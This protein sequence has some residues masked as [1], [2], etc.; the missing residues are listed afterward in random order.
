MGS[1]LSKSLHG[2]KWCSPKKCH[3]P[4]TVQSV[5]KRHN[6]SS[7]LFI[8]FLVVCLLPTTSKFTQ[9]WQASTLT[10][11]FRNNGMDLIHH[12]LECWQT[13][14]F[15]L[16]VL[17]ALPR[18]AHFQCGLIFNFEY[19]AANRSVLNRLR[20]HHRFRIEIHQIC[21]WKSGPFQTT[22]SHHTPLLSLTQRQ[23]FNLCVLILTYAHYWNMPLKCG[24][25]DFW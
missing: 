16:Q 19:S 15:P 18:R 23:Q 20:C 8:D 7:R 14:Y 6:W 12:W 2:H 25:R 1:S 4:F 3:W 22:G 17:S 5:H 21:Q 11:A 13:P 10:L 9:N 24:H